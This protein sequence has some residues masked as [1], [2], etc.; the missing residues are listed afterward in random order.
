MEIWL[1]FCIRK[2]KPKGTLTIIHRAEAV[3]EILSLL[4]DRMGKIMLI[5]FYPKKGVAPKRVIIQ[6]TKS[7]KAPF[8]IHPG[9]VLHQKNNKRT[10]FAE[11]IMRDAKSLNLF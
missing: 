3:S 11:S 4:K 9:Y 7:S 5:P 2:V 10:K 8:T 6:A 1:D